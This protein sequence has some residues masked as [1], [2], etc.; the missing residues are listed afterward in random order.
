MESAKIVVVGA[1]PGGLA[2]AVEAALSGLEGVLVLEKAGR[3]C[4]TIVN[5]YRQ[6]KRIDPVYRGLTVK[7][8]GSLSFDTMT[9][10]AF[11]DWM[12]ALP[13]EHGLDVR[14]GHEVVGV[15]PGN[16]KFLVICSNGFTVATEMVV[17]AIGVFGKP[18]KPS[19]PIAKEL[20]HLVHFNLPP[21]APT[22]RDLLVVGGGDSAA[23]AAC[24]LSRDNR[25]TLSYRR[26][27]FFRINEQNLCSVTHC[28]HFE[29]LTTKLGLNIEGIEKAMDDKVTVLYSD[30]QTADYHAVYY[31]LGGMTPAAFLEKAG[32]TLID[33]R[34]KIDRWG[35][36]EIPGLFLA[37]DLAVEKGSIMA[38]FNS[39]AQVI[40]GINAN[41]AARGT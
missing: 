18:V 40:K 8:E 19:Y 13:G 6:G 38:A 26:A 31:F 39:A 2:V 10:E 12:D 23:E 29:N 30:G 4:D 34:P 15:Q 20:R 14:C 1:G 25:V 9:K 37:G 16:G 17:I 3:P 5:L 36:T 21:E 24:F 22:G 41:S 7:P 11:L 27:E 33:G 35:Q 28:C 32:L